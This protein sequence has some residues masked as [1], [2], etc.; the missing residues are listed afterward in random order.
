[1][2]GP[3]T[4]HDEQNSPQKPT[5]FSRLRRIL[6]QI[7]RLGDTG[8][9]RIVELYPG[10]TFRFVD[11]PPPRHPGFS[12]QMSENAISSKKNCARKP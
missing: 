4:T 9:P 1:M 10:A 5:I 8:S 12:W 3:I 6:R 2:A 7:W 11:A